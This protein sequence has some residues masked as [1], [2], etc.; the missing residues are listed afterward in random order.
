MELALEQT[1]GKL[2]VFEYIVAEEEHKDGTPHL[3][4]YFNC[5]KRFNI[6]NPHR[7]DLEGPDGTKYHGNYQAVKNPARCK[8]YCKKGGKYITNMKFKLMAEAIQLAQEGK[9]KEAFDKIIE[10]RPDMILCNGAKVKANINMLAQDNV[11][12]KLFDLSEFKNLPA[13]LKLWR[14]NVHVLWFF[15]PTGTGKTELAKAHFVNPLLVRHA[16]QLKNLA[17]HDGLVFDDFNVGHWPREAAIH[18]TDIENH[19]GINV[20][21]G[22]VVI[23]AGMPRIFTSNTWIWPHDKTGAIK[24]RVFCVKCPDKMYET[25]MIAKLQAEKDP[26][27]WSDVQDECGTGE[28]FA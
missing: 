1:S 17:G 9:A 14:R 16:G 6:N 12:T 18:L 19:S 15:G 27:D 3:H 21:H 4:G 28:L 20:K 2:S 5:D 11:E 8:A 13:K 22:H 10:A 25:D 24:R 26:D 7:L 23:P